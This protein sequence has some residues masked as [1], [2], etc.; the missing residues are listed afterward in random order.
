LRSFNL[1]RY[2]TFASLVAITT[3][4]VATVW[5]FSRNLERS[6]TEEG[7]LYAADVAR[8]LNRSM[9]EGFLA[10]LAAEGRKVDLS[11]PGQRTTVAA[12][13][14]SNTRGLRILTVN[15]FDLSGTIVYSTNPAYIGYR[16]I[17]NPGLERALGGEVASFLK[18][19]E[20]ETDAIRHGH[21]MLETYTP[22]YELD[23]DSPRKGEVIGVFEL[24]QDAR[25]IVAKIEQGELEIALITPALLGL[26]FVALFE[27]VRRGHARIGRLSAELELS[28][29]ELE[30][31]V[32]SRTSEIEQAR[33]RLEALFDGI[34]DGISVIDREFRVSEW[35]SGIDRLFGPPRAGAATCHERYA[36]S[37]KP[38]PGCP[39]RI[40]AAT[41]AQAQRR[42][43]WPGPAG[44][45]REVEVV[46]FPFKTLE[47]ENAVIEVVRDVSERGELERQLVQSASLASL[48]ELAAGVAHEIRNP[49]GMI[50][51]SAQL[52][53]GA[54]GLAPS[55][56]E[57]VNVIEKE[58]NRV[59]ETITEFVGFAT[60][61]RPALAACEVP[62]LLER[63]QTMLRP[64]A[65]RRGI[66][67]EV[68]L[69]RDLPRALVDPELLHRAL[70]NL[71]LNALQVQSAGGRV[72]LSARRAGPGEIALCVAD[73]GPGIPAADLER[74]F[75]PF[76]SRRAGGTGLGLSIVQRIV[77][78]TGG[79]IAVASAPGGTTFTL[80]F[81]EAEP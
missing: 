33:G 73:R 34:A 61:T 17:D 47:N 43:R 71:I 36:Q 14:E 58:A 10:P 72:E 31:R 69:E 37:P 67:I 27:I 51:S 24:Y 29:R 70:A 38:C 52:L 44:A 65:E 15:L 6:L 19:A 76:F 55:D 28:N 9:F 60:P 35:N 56:R 59:A 62:P 30:V 2:F 1:L 12:I 4:A 32:A 8:S 78:A 80:F 41:G 46:T 7:G 40:T 81:P 39:A 75:Q 11:D 45:A 57:L 16:S 49:I 63:A 3:T 42:Y 68:S 54:E 23:P 13:V 53:E 22:F 5:T 48:G 66:H 18:R 21:D 26:L 74:I 79:R 25:P 20:L 64:E 50:R 77:T